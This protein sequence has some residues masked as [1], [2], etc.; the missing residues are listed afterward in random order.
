MMDATCTF[1]S[2]TYFYYPL[3]EGGGNY[4]ER[5]MYK[6]EWTPQTPNPNPHSCAPTH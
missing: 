6:L 4:D 1:W 2:S 3:Q 5:H